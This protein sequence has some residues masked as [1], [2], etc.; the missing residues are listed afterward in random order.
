M[1][2]GLVSVAL[3]TVSLFAVACGTSTG[4][5]SGSGATVQ[6]PDPRNATYRIDKDVLTIT[7]GKLEREAAPGS[8]TKIVTTVTD[9]QATGDLDGD[10]RPD[11]AVVLVN[12]PGGT[13]SFYY[14]A[15]L[16]NGS[17]G[18]SATPATLLGDR[19]AVTSLRLDGKTLV[20]D[21]LDHASGQPMAASPTVAVTKRFV[22]DAGALKAQ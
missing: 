2:R 20:V 8:A 22:V 14:L 6:A 10:G 15:V 16:L 1:T 13:G 7:N 5:G 18:V 3:A 19:I 17:S 21:L 4:A 9:T 12:Q 11:T